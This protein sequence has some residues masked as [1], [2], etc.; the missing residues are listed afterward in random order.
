MNYIN[1]IIHIACNSDLSLETKQKAIQETIEVYVANR[2]YQ[3]GYEN[4]LADGVKSARG[5][6]T[7]ISNTNH[8]NSSSNA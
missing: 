5:V 7:I 6:T 4:G 3:M 8:S 1:E 2:Q